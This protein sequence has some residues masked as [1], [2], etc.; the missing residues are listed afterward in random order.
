MSK[1]SFSGFIRNYCVKHSILHKVPPFVYSAVGNLT[2]QKGGLPASQQN[3]LPTGNRVNKRRKG[4]C[5]MAS[6]RPLC[7]N[8]RQPFFARANRP[9][10]AGQC[11][12]SWALPTDMRSVNRELFQT[13]IPQTQREPTSSWPARLP[14]NVLIS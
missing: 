10:R 2:K 9:T 14:G 1:P 13:V 11:S 12:P 4:D 5:W 7:T 6:P 3:M 8:F